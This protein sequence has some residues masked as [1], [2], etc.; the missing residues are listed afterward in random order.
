MTKYMDYPANLCKRRKTQSD[1]R[2]KLVSLSK[3][4]CFVPKIAKILSP[5]N[6]LKDPSPLK[7]LIKL[8]N[9]CNSKFQ[10]HSSVLKA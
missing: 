3:M 8:Q 7:G 10:L 4:E 1:N 9:E 2:Y 6:D 5:R